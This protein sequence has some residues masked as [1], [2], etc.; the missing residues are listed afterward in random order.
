[1]E[2]GGGIAALDRLFPELADDPRV[3]AVTADDTAVWLERGHQLIDRLVAKLHCVID[4][5]NLE[6]GHSLFKHS[7]EFV[8][9]LLAPVGDRHMEGIV[10]ARVGERLHVPVVQGVGE[11]LSLVLGRKV[12]HRRHAAGKSGLGTRLK[13]IGSHGVAD[14][15]IEMGM[16]VDK[17]GKD[18]FSVDVDLLRVGG[19][20]PADRY[21][22]LTRDQ[23]IR[24]FGAARRNQRAAF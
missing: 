19:K 1:M 22:L 6:R 5:I 10:T 15:Q 24:L 9:D 18:Q 4:H 11:R 2:Y 17:T 21:D 23:H 16:C 14:L 8:F 7:G 12:H 13:I 3:L 20:M